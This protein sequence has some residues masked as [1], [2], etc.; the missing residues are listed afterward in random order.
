MGTGRQSVASGDGPTCAGA[1]GGR[2]A[3]GFG[4]AAIHARRPHI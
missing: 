3:G 2:K 1:E 4:S